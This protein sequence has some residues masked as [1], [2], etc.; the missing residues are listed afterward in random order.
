MSKYKSR[1]L[2]DVPVGRGSRNSS[3]SDRIDILQFK[4]K[5]WTRI[6]LFGPVFCTG[7]YWVASKKKD[8]GDTRF[9]VVCPSFDYDMQDRNP[10]AYDPWR[11]AAEQ[12]NEYDPKNPKK[13][14]VLIQYSRNAWMNA[15]V[16]AEQKNAPRRPSKPTKAERKSGFKDKDSDSFT[17]VRAVRLTTSLLEKI[18]NLKGVNTY[19]AKNGQTKS[20]SVADLKYG[21]DIQVYYDKDAAPAN[22]YQVQLGEKRKPITEEES[23]YLVQNLELLADD[24]PSREEIDRDFYSWLKRNKLEIDMPGKKK[25]SKKDE[26]LLKKKKRKAVDDDDDFDDDDVGDD[27]DD[28]DDEDDE[29]KSKKKSKKPAKKSKSKKDEDDDDDFDDEDDDDFD[30]D[31]DDEDDDDDD[32][33]DD[34]SDD[35][36]DDS[37]DDSDDD[38]DDFDDEDDDDFDDDDEDDDSDDDDDDDDDSDDDDDDDDDEEDAPKSKK[39]KS[40]SSVKSKAS[41]KAPAKKSAKKA[42][43]KSAKSK[44][45]KK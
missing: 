13:N 42:D 40:K 31:D 17:P 15:I 19:E 35:D 45:G 10:E 28:F 27:D 26:E 5:T 24:V 34:D 7:Q 2:D 37:D 1:D 25:T 32:F 38:D 21:R 30:D 41:K 18:Q 16:R 6:R 11:T 20:Y 3:P 4:N 14:K 22:Q 12:L 33:D 8:G 44:K 29:P 9:P 23:E 36:D 39:S 43:K